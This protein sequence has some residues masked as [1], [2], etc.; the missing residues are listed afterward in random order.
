M[1][2]R[3]TLKEK[4]II[5]I[6]RCF[7]K[8]FDGDK[9]K[10][11]QNKDETI[12]LKQLLSLTKQS[13]EKW[14]FSFCFQFLIKWQEKR[15]LFF[16]FPLLLPL[17][18]APRNVAPIKNAWWQRSNQLPRNVFLQLGWIDC[19]QHEKTKSKFSNCMCSWHENENEFILLWGAKFSGVT[20]NN[21]KNRTKKQSLTFCWN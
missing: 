15:I 9:I 2:R 20:V 18:F 4:K 5:I 21:T 12:K 10:L 13:G 1:R 3:H 11:K 8:C 19:K 17:S 7:I 14:I 16:L 6:W